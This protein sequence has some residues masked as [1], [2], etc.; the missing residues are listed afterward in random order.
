VHTVVTRIA[1]VS[2]AHCFCGFVDLVPSHYSKLGLSYLQIEGHGDVSK[3]VTRPRAHMRQQLR[4]VGEAMHVCAH[5]D[6][7]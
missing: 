3:L 5:L 7:Q 1:D 6:P 2:N 4:V